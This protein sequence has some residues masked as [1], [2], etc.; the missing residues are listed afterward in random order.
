MEKRE[1]IYEG[2]AKIVYN[3][4]DPDLIIQYFKDDTTAFNAAKRGTV[5]NKGIIN[6][7]ISTKVFEFLNSEG[8]PT[9]YERRLGDREMLIKRAKIVPIEV[10]VRNKA[11]GSICRILGLEE[12][13]KLTPPVLE[14]CYKKDDLNDPLINEQHICALN[15]ASDEEVQTMKRYTL[16]INELMSKFFAN[17]NLELIDFKLEFGRYKGEIVLADEISPDTCRLW[18]IGT[19]KKFDKDRFRHDMGDIEEAYQEVLSRVSK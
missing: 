14:F 6:N 5:M 15:L 18:E 3:T 12:G 8:I 17:S 10:I 11:A 9:H 13:M 7:G 4:D 2:K 19:G 1:R 16:R